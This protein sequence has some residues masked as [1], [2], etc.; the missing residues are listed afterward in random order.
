MSVAIPSRPVRRPRTHVVRHFVSARGVEVGALQASPLLGAYLGGLGL[1]HGDDIR[2]ALLIVGSTALTA[3]IFVFNDWVDYDSDARDPRRERRGPSGNGITRKQIARLALA[4]LIL[5]AAALAALGPTELLMGAA[6]GFLGLLYSASSTFGKRT[7]GAATLN[8]LI[9]G[10]LHFLLGYEVA[11]VVDARGVAIGL[12]FGLVF[13]AGHFNQEVRD[14]EADRASAT[15]TSAVVF[16]PRGAFLASFC[17]FSAAYGL[18][19]VLAL[20]G[21]LPEVMLVV[22]FAW[23]LHGVWWQQALGRGPRLE[24]ALWMQSR[25]RVLFALVGLAML[26]H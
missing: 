23:L 13:A 24:T 18:I 25:Y 8:H 1:A 17:L 3:S 14:H 10:T 7:L 5:A 9:G 6:I 16:G 12:F 19:I 2:W 20:I 11:H 21:A 26:I 4:L 22:A 15:T